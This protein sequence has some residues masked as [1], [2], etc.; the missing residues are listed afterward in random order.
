MFLLNDMPESYRAL[1]MQLS[2]TA[3]QGGART[4]GKPIAARGKNISHQG[5]LRGLSHLE[6]KLRSRWNDSFDRDSVSLETV[7]KPINKTGLCEQ[8][9]ARSRNRVGQGGAAVP[10]INV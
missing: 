10:L 4:Q 2:I 7:L 5:S 8:K 1:A 3:S 9:D 6:S